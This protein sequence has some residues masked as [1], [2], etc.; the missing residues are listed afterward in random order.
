MTEKVKV[1]RSNLVL[2]GLL[3]AVLV[4]TGCAKKRPQAADS[5]NDSAN[6]IDKIRLGI[7]ASG[8]LV[9]DVGNYYGIFAKN[10]LE[11]ETV[12]F[13]AGINSIDAISIGQLDVGF[14]ADFAILNR[15]GGTQNSPL[16]IFTGYSVNLNTYELYSKDPAI[17]T[18]AD[19]AG[20]SVV[21]LLGTV[22]EYYYAKTWAA[23]GIPE[24]QIKYLPVDSALEAAAI[25]QAG[26]GQAFYA[27]GRAA[28]ALLAIDGVRSIGKLSDYVESTVAIFIASDRYLNEH[29]RAIEKFL[30][31]VDEIY[32]IV[33]KD[34]ETAADI[35]YKAS[36]IPRE[37]TL[38]NFKTIDYKIEFD[39]QFYDAMNNVL[40]WANEKGV[41]KYPYDLHNYVNVD[42]LK[43]VF[44]GRGNF[45]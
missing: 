20:K 9:P 5:P 15:I 25:I 21:T 18:P 28:E 44:P 11:V 45:K 2:T 38:L 33:L 17:K 37:L 19:L 41:I 24:S 42:S 3:V 35:V 10:N 7:M 4:F 26:S 8:T 40:Q 39:Q 1:T 13:A 34:Q 27:N 6:T 36:S 12:T 31:S 16:R 30:K 23:L 29:S 22:Y 32:S 43:K 14:A